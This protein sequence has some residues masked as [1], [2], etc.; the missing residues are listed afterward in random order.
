[1]KKKLF[2][3]LASVLCV[4]TLLLTA[5]SAGNSS[6]GKSSGAGA[7]SASSAVD[8]PTKPIELVVPYAAGGNVDLSCR[9]LASEVGKELGQSITV[10]NKE[11]G[12]AVIG[13][14]Y[15]INSKADGYTL[16]AQTSAYVSNIISGDASFK[17]DAIRPICMYCFDPELVVCSASSDIKTVEDLI[18]KGKKETLLNST[19]GAGTSHH[20]ASILFSQ[21]TGAQFKYMHTNG[22]A[23]QTVQLAGGHAE[24]GMT[25]Y[26]GAQ[27]L[28]K[29]GKIRVLAACADERISD[30]PDVPTLKEKGIDFTY[31][32][33][34]GI[35]VPAD[36]PDGVVK[37]LQDAF[38]KAMESDT[39]KQQFV[40]SGFP[41]TYKNSQ[42]FETYME[43]DYKSLESIKDLITTGK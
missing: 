11:G 23:E 18:S 25:T 6:G 32:A 13:Q 14:T 40:N 17:M 26:A 24:V 28:I 10:M 21:K 39:V 8:Y 3:R 31:G 42:E 37:I 33:Y 15:V 38:Q 4:S 41:I 1:M 36:T 35:G 29:D 2:V 5:C 19:P 16:L 12:G 27:S 22:S 34:R 43:D 30:L 20:I 9:I 7:Q